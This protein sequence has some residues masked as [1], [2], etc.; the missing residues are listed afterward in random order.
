MSPS[1]SS[2]HSVQPGRPSGFFGRFRA[3]IRS[4]LRKK[5][6]GDSGTPPNIYPLY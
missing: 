1:A 3:W 6:R 2:P 4:M 5:N